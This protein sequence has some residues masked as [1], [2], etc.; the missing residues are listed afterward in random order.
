MAKKESGKDRNF[1]SISV[2]PRMRED[3]EKISQANKGVALAVLVREAIAQ[4]LER[5]LKKL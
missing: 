4:Y 2:E 5:E 1:I 3:L